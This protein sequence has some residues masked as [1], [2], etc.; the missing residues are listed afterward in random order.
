MSAGIVP[1]IK[2]EVGGA[3]NDY[4]FLMH[5]DA[6]DGKRD[7]GDE[8]AAYIAQLQNAGAFQGGSAIGD[9]VCISKSGNPPGITSQVSGFIRVQAESL[10]RAR[11]FVSGNP[12]FEAG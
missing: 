11:E 2:T 1:K 5:N 7:R 10:N 4:I 12:V 3:M 6:K 8:W 9:G